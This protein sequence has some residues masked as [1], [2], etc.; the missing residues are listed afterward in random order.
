MK[1]IQGSSNIEIRQTKDA[2][3]VMYITFENTQGVPI[4]KLEINQSDFVSSL[5][6]SGFRP[7]ELIIPV[8]DHSDLVQLI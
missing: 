1:V 2:Q 6:G 4:L 3:T 7:S 5:F 8:H